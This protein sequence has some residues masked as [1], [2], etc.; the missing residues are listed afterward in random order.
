MKEELSRGRAGSPAQATAELSSQRGT[1]PCW[2][3]IPAAGSLKNKMAIHAPD[4]TDNL[5]QNNQWDIASQDLTMNSSREWDNFG[6]G[7]M[8][9]LRCIGFWLGI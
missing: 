8:S 9:T 5:R 6:T 4:G 1:W 7:S 2:R 3:R